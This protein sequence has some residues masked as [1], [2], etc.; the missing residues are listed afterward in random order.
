MN[1]RPDVDRAR[2]QIRVF[3][4]LDERSFTVNDAWFLE[5]LGFSMPKDM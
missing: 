4:Y 2:P 3:A 1:V 5:K